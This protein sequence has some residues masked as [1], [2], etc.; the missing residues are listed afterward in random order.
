MSAKFFRISL[1]SINFPRTLFGFINEASAH[2]DLGPKPLGR[3][4]MSAL[5]LVF[6]LVKDGGG[7]RG[8]AGGGVGRGRESGV[9]GW[10]L[11]LTG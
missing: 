8:R 5:P 11:W 1:T 4:F 2:W 10:T 9:S 7:E 6:V 3:I